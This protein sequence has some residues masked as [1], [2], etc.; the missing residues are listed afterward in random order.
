MGKLI[1][2]A[3]WVV[4]VLLPWATACSGSAS[5]PHVDA[6]VHGSEGDPC[7]LTGQSSG[8]PACRGKLKCVESVFTLG[9]CGRSCKTN[10]DCGNADEVCYSYSGQAKDGHCVNLIKDEYGRCGVGDTSICDQRSC[11]YLPNQ[12]V[13]VCID[14]C[15]LDG[16]PVAAGDGGV[17]ASADEDAGQD[18]TAGASGLGAPAGAV[19]CPSSESCVDNVLADA[20]LNEGVC[21]TVVGRGDECGIE[22]GIYCPSGDICAPEDPND[23]SSKLRCFQDCSSTGSKCDKGKCVTVQGVFAYCL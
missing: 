22:Q 9:V 18:P 7:D 6:G 21:G 14:T 2:S 10:T 19:E 13:G 16:S 11:L 20:M 23:L 17:D 12:P 4:I 5:T 8:L 3:S 15:A 1:R